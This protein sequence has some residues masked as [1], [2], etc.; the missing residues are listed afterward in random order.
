[1]SKAGRRTLSSSNELP[2]SRLQWS[3]LVIIMAVVKSSRQESVLSGVELE[4]CSLGATDCRRV[5]LSCITQNLSFWDPLG[6]RTQ[7][8]SGHQSD[9]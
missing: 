4:S 1:M 3:S 6:V 7:L 9:T 8:M 5:Y 2:V